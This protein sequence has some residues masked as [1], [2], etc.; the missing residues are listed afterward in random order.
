MALSSTCF[1]RGEKKIIFIFL[2]TAMGVGEASPY[3]PLQM[4]SFDSEISSFLYTESV[5][6]IIFSIGILEI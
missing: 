6:W 2:F 1:G 5:T 4:Y 3:I